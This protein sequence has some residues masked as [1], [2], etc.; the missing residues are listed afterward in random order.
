MDNKQFVGV[1]GSLPKVGGVEVEVR[2]VPTDKRYWTGRGPRRHQLTP[3]VPRILRLSLR[4]RTTRVLLQRTTRPSSFSKKNHRRFKDLRS[5][6][7][8]GRWKDKNPKSIG[9]K[10][11]IGNER[12]FLKIVLVRYTPGP[13]PSTFSGPH[14]PSDRSF[15]YT[16]QVRTPLTL[17]PVSTLLPLFVWVYHNLSWFDSLHYY[18]TSQRVVNL[19]GGVNVKEHCGITD[20]T[21]ISLLHTILSGHRGPYPG[22]FLCTVGSRN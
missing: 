12:W 8:L 2:K 22:L 9:W 21:K 16:H 4:D 6:K 17:E 1:R 19:T 20:V 14:C 15:Q 18:L 5:I 7:T 11:S 3:Q 13:L 10:D